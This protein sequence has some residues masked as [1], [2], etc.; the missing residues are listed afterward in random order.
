MDEQHD[1][2]ASEF[3]YFLGLLA[4][5][6]AGAGVIGCL[7]ANALWEMLVVLLRA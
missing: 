1:F 2:D 5:L 6:A 3:W 7:A 4:L